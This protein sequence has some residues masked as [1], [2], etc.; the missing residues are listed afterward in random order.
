LPVLEAMA[1]GL[2][3]IVSLSA[4]ISEW[5]I[6]GE[7]SLLLADPANS[8]ELAEK[9]KTLVRDPNLRERIAANA[10]QKAKT[11]SWDTHANAIREL[12]V[13][14]ALRKSTSGKAPSQKRKAR[15]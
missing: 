12:L 10:I 6:D 9:I 2:P 11:F 14:A 5:L 15:T 1:C 4:G 8:S 3:A 13:A 7:D